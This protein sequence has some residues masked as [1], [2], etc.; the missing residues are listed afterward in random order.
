[1][2]SDDS[3]WI[4]ATSL[5]GSVLVALVVISAGVLDASPA[6]ENLPLIGGVGGTA[7]TSE[8]PDNHVLTG[9][10]YR[11]GLLVDAIGIKCRPVRADGTL[12]A[13]INSGNL[14]GGGGGTAGSVSCPIGKVVAWESGLSSGAGISKLYFRCYR[15]FPA[16]RTWAGE[17]SPSLVVVGNGWTLT[18]HTCSA[19]TAPATGI[20]GRNG[21]I[22]DAVGLHCSIP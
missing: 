13:E 18:E 6:V 4:A 1:M 3:R 8:C 17:E 2:R 11:R 22:V 14:V 7:F 9:F 12:G 10:R 20:R 5:C 15:W 21:M 19:A 16:S